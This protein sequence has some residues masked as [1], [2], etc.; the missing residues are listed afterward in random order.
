M[1]YKISLDASKSLQSSTYQGTVSL[2]KI[3]IKGLRYALKRNFTSL[4]Q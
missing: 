4:E 1:L 3:A 2:Q